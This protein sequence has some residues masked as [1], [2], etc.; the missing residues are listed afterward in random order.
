VKQ[1]IT[2]F[3]ETAR[4]RRKMSKLRKNGKRLES[5]IKEYNVVLAWHQ[6]LLKR[7]TEAYEVVKK[8]EEMK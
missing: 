3:L 6:E 7:A 8:R 1:Y 2:K 5:L 4:L